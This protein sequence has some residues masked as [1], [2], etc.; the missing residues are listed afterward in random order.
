VDELL[1]FLAEFGYWPYIIA[2]NNWV[3]VSRQ[4]LAEWWRCWV[5]RSNGWLDVYLAPKGSTYG[6]LPPHPDW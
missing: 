6:C 4:T 2:G 3:P 5:H 1:A